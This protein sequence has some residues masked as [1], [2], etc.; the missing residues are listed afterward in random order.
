MVAAGVAVVDL[1]GAAHAARL[2]PL[3][4]GYL[5]KRPAGRDE[6]GRRG[7]GA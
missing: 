1:H 2:M 3:F 7:V 4:G 6:V 5:E